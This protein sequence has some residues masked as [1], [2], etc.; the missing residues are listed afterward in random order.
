MYL[1]M[2]Q[3]LDFLCK[4]LDFFGSI[5]DTVSVLEH[6]WIA[7]ILDKTLAETLANFG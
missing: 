5:V 4:A 3:A 1:A 7:M 2:Y 6:H